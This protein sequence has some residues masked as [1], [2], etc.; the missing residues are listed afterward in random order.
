MGATGSPE[1][2]LAKLDTK[3]R[4]LAQQF[5]TLA[6][7]LNALSN[8]L[9]ARMASLDRISNQLI[10][11]A[12]RLRQLILEDD[13]VG[14]V[15]FDKVAIGD[16]LE[17]VADLVVDLQVATGEEDL[18]GPITAAFLD[19]YRDTARWHVPENRL[20]WHLPLQR[21]KRVYWHRDA[22]PNHSDVVSEALAVVDRGCT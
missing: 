19:G 4:I 6:S 3:A 8:E 10:H 15:D 20:Q 18:D 13:R 5:P 22:D 1:D 21:M 2:L 12:F 16:P 14:I 11:G 17:D 9:A 7:P